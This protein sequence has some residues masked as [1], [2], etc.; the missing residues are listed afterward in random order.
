MVALMQN[1]KLTAAGRAELSKT[2][3]G[4]RKLKKM[5]KKSS[6]KKYYPVQRTIRCV[7]NDPN[8]Q[9]TDAFELRVDHELSKA[10][11]RLYRQSRVYP[12]KLDIDPSFAGVTVEVY[13]LRPTWMNM[14]A[15]QE[16]YN[17]FVKNSA[18]ERNP[19]NDA[20]WN[21][22]RVK[23]NSG[24]DTLLNGVGITD[25][26]DP[27]QGSLFSQGEYVYSEVHGTAGVTQTF[28]WSGGTSSTV[29]DIIDEYDNMANTDASPS[30]PINTVSYDGLEDEIDDGQKDHLQND[31][32]NPPY[33][34]SSIDDEVYTRV[35]V[36][37][38]GDGTPN[39]QVSKL[40]TGFFD[41]P[42]GLVIIKTS[43]PLVM[44]S[45]APFTF[46]VKAGDYKGVEAHPM[47]EL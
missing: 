27:L 24:T 8:N 17:Q 7:Q 39:N 1:G 33:A 46:T 26:S 2:A 29:F 31:G 44:A 45:E 20:R 10:N 37:R 9:N 42:C 5:S 36:L 4:R 32:N 38:A 41:A 12:V 30:S 40:S 13:A 19:G 15:Y 18:E 43:R 34:A 14:N 11:Q 23:S 47:L 16:A 6:K 3:A 21:D 35:A 22:F 25:V 28:A